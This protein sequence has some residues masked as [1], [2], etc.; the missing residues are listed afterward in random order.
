MI[1]GYQMKLQNIVL[2]AGVLFAT[3]AFAKIPPAPPPDP[4]AAAAKAEK[5]KATAEKTKADQARYED[6]AVANFQTNMKKAGKPVPKPT[7]IVVAVAPPAAVIAPA[8]AGKPAAVPAK[9]EK[10][11]A[12]TKK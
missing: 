12:T 7:P 4:V 11:G 5:D 3:N 1:K 9:D 10:S 8:A 2:A 6:R